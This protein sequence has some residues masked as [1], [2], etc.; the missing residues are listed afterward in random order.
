MKQACIWPLKKHKKCDQSGALWKM[1]PL[2]L[3][4]HLIPQVKEKITWST[5]KSS[6]AVIRAMHWLIHKEE[7]KW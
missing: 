7:N 3:I 6:A 2:N 4:K 1:N 5:A